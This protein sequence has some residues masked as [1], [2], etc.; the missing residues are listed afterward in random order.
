LRERHEKC[1]R[2]GDAIDKA[3]VDHV[4]EFLVHLK[5]FARERI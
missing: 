5:R 2:I 4:L 1:G 3:R